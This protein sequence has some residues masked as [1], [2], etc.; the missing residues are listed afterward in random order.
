[1]HGWPRSC[2]TISSTSR[3]KF[4]RASWS[5]GRA[6]S[7]C[8]ARPSVRVG[9]TSRTSG[10]RRPSRACARGRSPAASPLDVPAQCLGRRSGVDAV[11]PVRL[12]EH[13]AEEARLAVQ[14]QCGRHAARPCA[15]R[16][17]TRRRRR[18]RRAAP[19]RGTGPPGSRGGRRRRARS[20]RGAPVRAAGTASSQTGRQMP[21]VRVYQMPPEPRCLPRGCVPV[22]GVVHGDDELVLARRADRGR[23]RSACNRRCASRPRSR[24]RSPPPASRP[25][26]TAAG[27]ASP[28]RPAGS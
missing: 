9:R 6:G 12:V 18:R 27:R 8:P 5:R 13:A 1:M 23:T 19:R 24:R 25:R 21:V 4:W 14:V 3:T 11:G 17:R 2:P 26:R 15:A 20:P 22:G 10:G 28:P 16:S 7:G